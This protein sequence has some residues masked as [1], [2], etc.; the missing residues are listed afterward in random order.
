MCCPPLS[1]FFPLLEVQSWKQALLVPRWKWKPERESNLTEAAQWLEQRQSW[2]H[3]PVIVLWPLVS[4]PFSKIGW[5]DGK[6]VSFW[7]VTF[8]FFGRTLCYTGV[9]ETRRE[10][11]YSNAQ[12]GSVTTEK[13][14]DDVQRCPS[15]LASSVKQA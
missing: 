13:T 3:T 7:L 11:Q 2:D 12:S 10:R 8:F 4:S 9:R 6:E 15:G 5:K 1:L 14:Q